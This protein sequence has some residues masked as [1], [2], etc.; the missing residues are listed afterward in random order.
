MFIVRCYTIL[1]LR[2]E[3]K[4]TAVEMNHV[5]FMRFV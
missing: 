3:K 2:K 1:T 4:S 5:Y